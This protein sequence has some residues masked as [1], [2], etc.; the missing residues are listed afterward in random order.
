MNTAMFD[1]QFSTID[2][3]QLCAVAGGKSFWNKVGHSLKVIGSD[4][5]NGA[6]VGAAGGGLGGF[7]VGGPAGAGIG[8]AG[9][10]ALGAAAGLGYGIGHEIGKAV[11]K[12]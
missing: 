12:K 3:D 9:G 2:L 7:V 4:M 10:G 1:T 8:G 6:G 5:V 11:K